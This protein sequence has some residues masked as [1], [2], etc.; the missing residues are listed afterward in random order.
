MGVSATWQTLTRNLV[1]WH[2][3]KRNYIHISRCT[4]IKTRDSAS[5]QSHVVSQGRISGKRKPLTRDPTV[6]QKMIPLQPP[7]RVIIPRRVEITTHMRLSH[8]VHPKIARRKVARFEREVRVAQRLLAEVVQAVLVM[9]ESTSRVI[10]SAIG[11]LRVEVEQAVFLMVERDRERSVLGTETRR[12]V[13]AEPALVPPL[14]LASATR[15]RNVM[16]TL[17]HNHFYPFL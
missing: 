4:L 3:I 2:A 12:A 8:P 9:R 1:T 17:F 7:L 6:L 16:H 11:E 5:L 13:K 10:L 15:T 14:V